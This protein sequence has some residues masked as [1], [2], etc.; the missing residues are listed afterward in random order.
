MSDEYQGHPGLDADDTDENLGDG[1]R[2][3]RRDRSDIV[4]FAA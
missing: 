2:K 1:A 3:T 4:V